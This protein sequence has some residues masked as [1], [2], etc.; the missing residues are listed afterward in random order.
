MYASTSGSEEDWAIKQRRK[1]RSPSAVSQVSQHL[2]AAIAWY[3]GLIYPL[4]RTMILKPS[5]LV[6]H[7]QNARIVYSGPPVR[8]DGDLHIQSAHSG[9]RVFSQMQYGPEW[10]VQDCREWVRCD[11]VQRDLGILSS[12]PAL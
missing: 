10:A 6:Q 9:Y 7:G 8:S 1:L 11:L 3:A 12:Q 5:G 2:R 4:F